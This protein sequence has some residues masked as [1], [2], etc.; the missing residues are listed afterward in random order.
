M[1][2]KLFPKRAR[3]NSCGR[4]RKQEAELTGAAASHERSENSGPGTGLG[5]GSPT[6]SQAEA[7]FPVRTIH[8][9]K[10]EK[11]QSQ[12]SVVSASEQTQFPRLQDAVDQAVAL[13][14]AKALEQLQE[15]RPRFKTVADGG[16]PRVPDARDYMNNIIP[17]AQKV[18]EAKLANAEADTLSNEKFRDAVKDFDQAVAEQNSELLRTQIQSEF[19]LIA[20]TAGPRIVGSGTI[21]ERIDSGGAE[22]NRPL[23]PR[24]LFPFL[25]NLRFHA[26]SFRT[27]SLDVTDLR[28][29]P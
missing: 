13:G 3:R 12:D 15:I 16:G 1:W 29:S 17:R 21:P 28:S 25:T 19:R 18:I 10:S 11:K 27:P 2:M 4:A 8:T 6:G 14:D 5:R 7:R 23:T 20:S 9:R 26:R 22:K 24:I